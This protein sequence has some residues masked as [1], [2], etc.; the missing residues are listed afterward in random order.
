ME[1]TLFKTSIDLTC[2]VNKKG[3]LN[4]AIADYLGESLPSELKGQI[5]DFEK[6]APL[7]DLILKQPDLLYIVSTFASQGANKNWDGFLRPVMA[8]IFETAEHKFVDYE[9]DVDAINSKTNPDKYEIVG[10]IYDSSLAAQETGSLIPDYEVYFDDDGKLFCKDSPYR[11]QGIDIVVAW[12]LYQFQYPDLADLL[13]NEYLK[14]DNGKFGVSMEIL[15]SDYKFRVG[16]FDP[17]EDFDFDATTV[18]KI[19]GKK[20][21]DLGNELKSYWASRK[22]YNN[23][24]V[25]RIFGGQVFFSG[26]AI[27]SNRASGRSS[28][29][30]IASISDVEIND[31][32]KGFIALLNAVA[33]RNKEVDLSTCKI[34]N[35]EPD[36][37]C[38]ENAIAG[39]L[40]TLTINMDK[41]TE[42]FKNKQN[43]MG[44]IEQTLAPEQSEAIQKRKDVNPKEGEKKYGA[45]RFA[46]PKN[47][48]YPID[49]EEHIRAAWN[50]INHKDNSGKYSSK[51]A[52]K[53]KSRII[54]AWKSKI[55]KEGPPSAAKADLEE[56]INNISQ[57]EENDVMDHLDNA[58]DYLKRA[59]NYLQNLYE[60]NLD[61]EF[62]ADDIME[63]L[64]EIENILGQ[65]QECMK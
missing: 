32:N 37:D 16:E 30:A 25:T 20:D 47:K 9:H 33:S 10:H 39:E 29:K 1:K 50:Y 35:G 36:C 56:Y 31:D 43:G 28:N 41:F 52:S 48:K 17:N 8:R 3:A 18:G 4:K 42:W 13:V 60:N 11:N 24:P 51:D 45:V 61:N 63:S 26:M 55:S 46:D 53:I 15:F 40:D 12:V 6:I 19:E 5:S 2:K 23:Q 34:I 58:T 7:K 49:T 44:L 22:L 21:T 65:A 62:S 54:S 64:E 38:L 57:I 59:N 27:T 14:G